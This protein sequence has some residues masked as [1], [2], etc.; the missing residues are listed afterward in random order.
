MKQ[1]SSLTLQMKHSLRVTMLCLREYI[2]EG[3]SHLEDEETVTDS[4]L[5]QPWRY[6]SLGGLNTVE[7]ENTSLRLFSHR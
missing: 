4:V 2:S 3:I 7:G 1:Y 5:R 6:S